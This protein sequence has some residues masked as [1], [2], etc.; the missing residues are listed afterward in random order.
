MIVGIDLG[1]TKTHI[2]AEQ[3]G[4]TIEEF[5]AITADWQ[6]DGPLDDTHNARRLLAL[7]KSIPRA[8]G[9]ALVIGAHGLDTDD[10]CLHFESLLRAEH[11]GPVRAVNDAALLGPAAGFDESIAV[12]VGTGSKIVSR[13]AGGETISA[14]G[15]GHLF[16]D[17]G[18]AG[19]LVR[20]ATRAILN[21][22]DK[23]HVPDRLATAFMDF[24]GV[25]NEVELAQRLTS[26]PRLTSWAIMAPLLFDA[27]AE[28]SKLAA[29][30]ADNAA[31]ELAHGVA[32]VHARGAVGSNVVCSGG[33]IVRQPHL[34]RAL[35]ERVD[36]LNLGLQVSLLDVDPVRGALALAKKLQ[37]GNTKKKPMHDYNNRQGDIR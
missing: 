32:L 4:Q 20:E 35:V 29:T 12:V 11:N 19:G 21:A 37:S 8:K 24:L 2:V 7:L 30:V 6:H 23:G 25:G 16:S 15:Y 5:V 1:A 27:L 28:G 22:R 26:D 13:T 36:E 34:F 10:Q 14:G 3:N 18:S 33:V 17:P 31:R 9:A